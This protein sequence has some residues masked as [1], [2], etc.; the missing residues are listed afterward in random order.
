MK[1][2]H[3]RKLIF[4]YI[5]GVISEPDR[6]GLEQHLVHC[7]SCEN[8]ATTLATSLD[9]L[10]RL[11]VAMP[12][13]NFSWKLRLRI[14]KEKNAW[15][16][17]VESE[18]AWQRAWNRKFAFG[19]I[20]AFV[21]VVAAGGFVLLRFAAGSGG[22]VRGTEWRPGSL[23]GRSAVTSD[24]YRNRGVTETPGPSVFPWGMSPGPQSVSLDTPVGVDLRE[25]QGDRWNSLLEG[26][27][28]L[29]LTGPGVDARRVRQ[30]E[31]QLELLQIELQKCNLERKR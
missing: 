30:L 24:D 14:A 4:D 9:L 2:R 13:E 29:R 31:A 19:T 26:D 11:P 5:D 25:P 1:C 3:A 21:V 22:T 8:A 16:D 18:R 15:R 20:S 28:L 10:H 23:A 7:R 27:S 17:G 12:S 6:A